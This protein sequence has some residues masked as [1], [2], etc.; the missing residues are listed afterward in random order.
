MRASAS[1]CG[2]LVNLF[3]FLSSRCLSLITCVSTSS[4]HF[5]CLR[6]VEGNVQVVW[7]CFRSANLC[8][9]SNLASHGWL[10]PRK[11]VVFPRIR[12]TVMF[13]YVSSLSLV[14]LPSA[15]SWS[16]TGV[17]DAGCGLPALPKQECSSFGSGLL[18]CSF[19]AAFL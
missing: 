6:F 1:I 19:S 2:R 17:R 7:G 10:V 4:T 5:F 3:S 12:Q 11:R 16:H 13:T 8:V 15:A 14:T 18:L 9:Q